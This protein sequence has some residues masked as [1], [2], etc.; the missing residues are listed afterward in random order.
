MTLEELR[1]AISYF[2]AICDVFFWLQLTSMGLLYMFSENGRIFGI[3]LICWSTVDLVGPHD[4]TTPAV[5]S[6]P[7]FETD[8][9]GFQ[10]PVI[11]TGGKVE[12]WGNTGV[13][14]YDQQRHSRLVY[15][16]P[17]LVITITSSCGGCRHLFG[18]KGV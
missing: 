10:V 3:G 14:K 1:D 11:G 7:V 8:H 2:E 12:N 5:F 13:H 15:A 17:P 6:F 4:S 18:S 16:S 9:E